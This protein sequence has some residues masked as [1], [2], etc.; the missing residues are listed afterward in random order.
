MLDKA[1]VNAHLCCYY[2]AIHK[3]LLA[4]VK[5]DEIRIWYSSFPFSLAKE[6][7]CVRGLF[8]I[9]LDHDKSNDDSFLTSSPEKLWSLIKDYRHYVEVHRWR[10]DRSPYK[11][12]FELLEK[13]YSYKRFSRDK[14]ALIFDS[15]KNMLKTVC[16]EEVKEARYKGEVWSSLSFIKSL[17]IKYCPYC[18]AE[19]VYS[20]QFDGDDVVK[21]ARSAL[22]HYFPQSEYPFLGISLCNLVPSC[23]RCNTDIKRDREMD[24]ELH[25]NPYSECFHD[26][27]RF[28][29]RPVDAT[30]TF[31]VDC[32]KSEEGFVFDTRPQKDSQPNLANRGIALAEFFKIKDVYN[33]LFKHEAINYIYKSRLIGSDYYNFVREMLKENLTEAQIKM[34]FCD[35]VDETYKINRVRLSKLA[36]DMHQMVEE[37]RQIAKSRS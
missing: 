32:A 28:I 24:F 29:C 2:D 23:T 37:E 22:D 27:V 6:S 5:G 18:N 31:S 19:T 13:I 25:L 26:A 10:K 17:N 1:A 8:Q 15:K 21:S 16:I 36:L 9:L 14:K 30:V 11:E 20:I 12:C 34:L 3:A 35:L 7:G 33:Q 4:L